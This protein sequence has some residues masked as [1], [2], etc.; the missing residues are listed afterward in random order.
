MTDRGRLGHGGN[1]RS[2]PADRMSREEAGK[3]V[4]YLTAQVESGYPWR[5]ERLEVE[6]QSPFA[7]LVPSGWCP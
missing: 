2:C 4:D 3:M 1:D 7:I 6:G 5:G